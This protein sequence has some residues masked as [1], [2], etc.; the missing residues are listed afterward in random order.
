MPFLLDTAAW[1]KKIGFKVKW[2]LA[3]REYY[4]CSVL[5]AFKEQGIDVITVAKDYKQLQKTKEAYRAG[6][7]GRVWS[8]TIRSGAKAGSIAR[9]MQCWLVLY[10]KKKYSLQAIRRDLRHGAMTVDGACKRTY[11]LITT[12][13]PQG[14]GKKFPALIHRPYRTR[15][16]IETGYRVADVKRSSWR[17]D[18]DGIRFMDEMGRMLLLQDLWQVARGEDP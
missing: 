17:S 4:S 10:P 7:K 16:K 9:S 11:G 2:A 12:A 13:A 14:H 6:R 1:L 15:W 8:F 18:R 5:S 3:D